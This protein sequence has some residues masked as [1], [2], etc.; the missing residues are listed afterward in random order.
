MSK[1][2]ENCVSKGMAGTGK[3]AQF[4]KRFATKPDDLNWIPGPHMVEEKNHLSQVALWPKN[5][6]T[7][8]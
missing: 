6:Y 3:M 1:W 4:I 5:W 8:K 2:Q 7:H